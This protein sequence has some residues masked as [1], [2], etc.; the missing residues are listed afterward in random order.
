MKPFIVDQVISDQTVKEKAIAAYRANNRKVREVIPADR[1]LVFNVAEGWEP[2][3]AF[4]GVPVPA[5]SFPHHH[6]RQEVW[7]RFGGEPGE[8]MSAAAE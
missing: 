4:L 5:V 2:P 3:C 8:P 7:E 1:L 6:P